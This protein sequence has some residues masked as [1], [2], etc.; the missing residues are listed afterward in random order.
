LETKRLTSKQIIAWM[1]TADCSLNTIIQYL[2][3]CRFEMVDLDFEKSKPIENVFNCFFKILEKTGGYPKPK[4]YKSFQDKKITIE[5]ELIEKQENESLELKKLYQRKIE[6]EQ[7]KK[8]W[9]MMSEPEGKLYKKC[10]EELN[11]FQKKKNKGKAFEM[12]MK[13]IFKKL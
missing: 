3:S 5:R 7:D 1:K 11:N 13:D 12:S 2:C 4:D 6:A 10:F 9:S 8:F